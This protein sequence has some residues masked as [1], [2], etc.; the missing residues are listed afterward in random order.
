MGIRFRR[1]VPAMLLLCTTA[2]VGQTHDRPG[3]HHHSP[4]ADEPRSAVA[5]LSAGQLDQLEKGEGMGLSR[6]AELNRY[7][8]PVHVLDAAEELG[9]SD[10]QRRE[11]RRILDAMKGDAVRLGKEIIEKETL[12]SRR[13][14]HRHVDE[15]FL[16]DLTTEIGLLQGKLRLVHLL[17]HLRTTALLSNEQIARYDEL[18]GY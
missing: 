11:T 5:S 3:H 16:R 18:R 12:L 8:G 15:E 6:A 14:A 2:V 17:A 4:Y 9:L 7:P 13:F 1:F 10:E